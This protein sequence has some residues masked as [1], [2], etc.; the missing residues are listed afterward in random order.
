MSENRHDY[1]TA[2]TAAPLGHVQPMP[3]GGPNCYAVK[4]IGDCMAPDVNDGDLVLC[5]PDQL[6]MAGDYVAVWW[7][8][9][10]RPPNIKRL[11]TTLPPRAFWDNADFEAVVVVEQLNPPKRLAADMTRVEAVHKVLGKAEAAHG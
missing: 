11:V 3:N 8:G 9:G 7:K 1:Q 4:T 10:E 2:I 5:D 6:P